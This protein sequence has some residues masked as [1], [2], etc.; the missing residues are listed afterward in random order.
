MKVEC[1]WCGRKF[2]DKEPLE[3][4]GTSHTMCD[5]CFEKQQEKLKKTKE[6]KREKKN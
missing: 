5:A 2:P 4:K 1:A 6:A 3:N